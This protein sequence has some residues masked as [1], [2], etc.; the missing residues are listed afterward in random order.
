MVTLQCC[1]WNPHMVLLLF[2]YLC[3]LGCVLTFPRMGGVMAHT[4]VVQFVMKSQLHRKATSDHSLINTTGGTCV[5]S[6][7][8][9][10]GW[11]TGVRWSLKREILDFVSLVSQWIFGLQLPNLVRW[12]RRLWSLTYA[13]S[14]GKTGREVRQFCWPGLSDSHGRNENKALC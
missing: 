6:W 2:S 9:Q 10:H 5:H 13:I 3:Q 11:L 12:N 14:T 4:C 7:A 8:C 1:F